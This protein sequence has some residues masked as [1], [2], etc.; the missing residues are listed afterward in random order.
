[1]RHI[2]RPNLKKCIECKRSLPVADFGVD[3]RALNGLNGRCFAC[4]SVCAKRYRATESGKAKRLQW[5]RS[6]KGKASARR[7]GSSTAGKTRDL[8]WRQTDKGREA[9]KAIRAR[10][11]PNGMK[12]KAA[13]AVWTALRKGSII[14]ESCIYRHADKKCTGRVEAHHSSYLEDNRLLVVWLCDLHHKAEHRRLEALG[15]TGFEK[16]VQ[17]FIP[18]KRSLSAPTGADR[19]LF[20]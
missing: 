12:G 4:V 1:M 19:R 7:Y 5:R 14:A 16:A 6:D 8:R 17:L 3:R 15:W 13:K 10:N 11:D 18:P 9:L 2:R 20:V